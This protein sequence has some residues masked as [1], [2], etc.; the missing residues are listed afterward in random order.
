MSVELAPAGCRCFVVLEV[1]LGPTIWWRSSCVGGALALRCPEPLQEDL[2]DR[3]GIEARVAE[4]AALQPERV[5]DAEQ[6][7]VV[8]TLVELEELSLPDRTARQQEGHV[9]A[10]VAVAAAD[11]ANIGAKSLRSTPAP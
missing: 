7:I 10:R 1:R 4:G 6:E 2:A 8:G 9:V 5:T 3:T 11:L